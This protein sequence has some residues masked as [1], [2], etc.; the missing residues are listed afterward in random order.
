MY[1]FQPS[2][3]LPPLTWRKHEIGLKAWWLFFTTLFIDRCCKKYDCSQVPALS[4]YLTNRHLVGRG[5]VGWGTRGPKSFHFSAMLGQKLLPSLKFKSHFHIWKHTTKL[6]SMTVKIYLDDTILIYHVLFQL[7]V[8][9]R[10]FTLIT[11]SNFFFAARWEIWRGCC[12]ETDEIVPEMLEIVQNHQTR[13]TSLVYL[14]R[15]MLHHHFTSRF[16]A[17]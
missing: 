17:R 3:V 8:R 4:N 15:K 12:V 10:D 6:P 14:S 11:K 9:R 16:S 5:W 7:R 2:N 13:K 1:K